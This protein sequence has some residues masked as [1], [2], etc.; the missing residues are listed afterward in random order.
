MAEEQVGYVVTNAGQDI[1]TRIITGLNV[2]FSKIVI[3]DGYDHDTTNFA[4]RTE[5]ANEVLSLNIETMQITN[6][7]VIELGAEFSKNDINTAF[8]FREIGVYIIDPDDET[9][10]ILF[11]YGN[12]NEEA[13]YI[14]PHVQNYDILKTIKCL[15]SVGSSA[16]VTVIVKDTDG[17]GVYKFL[18]NSWII[19]EYGDPYTLN[20]GDLGDVFKVFISSGTDLVE[21]GIVTITK[22]SANNT[23]LKSLTPFDGCVYYL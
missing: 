3:G 17:V 7:K 1:I 10:E 16:N 12:R 9:K 20:L 14:T 19:E 5:L 2:T 22:D 6:S 18:A 21:T 23:I 8:W 15:I 13:E 11:A 4:A